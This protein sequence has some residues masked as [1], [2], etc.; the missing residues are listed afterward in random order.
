MKRIIVAIAA[1]IPALG[2]AGGPT[3]MPDAAVSGSA[4]IGTAKHAWVTPKGAIELDDVES[5]NDDLPRYRGKRVVV[6]G[7]V[8]DKVDSKSMVIESGGIFNDELLVVAGPMLKESDLARFQENHEVK[9]SGTV[10]MMTAEQAKKEYGWNPTASAAERIKGRKA[11]LV[12]DQ[13]ALVDE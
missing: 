9:V 2:L 7:E 5:L 13:I 6:T 10:R 8:E 4:A 11:F 1:L 12:A 3:N